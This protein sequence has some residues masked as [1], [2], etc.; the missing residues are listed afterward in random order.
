MTD[1][2]LTREIALRIALAARIFPDMESAQLVRILDSA[3]GLPP[4]AQGI[5]K[6]NSTLLKTAADGDLDD[7]EGD[8]IEQAVAVLKGK[9]VTEEVAPPTVQPY[10]EGEMSGSVRVACSSNTGEELDGHFG[11]CQRFLIYQISQ[12]E[13]RLIDIREPQSPDDDEDKNTL[14]AELIAD[15]HVLL[16]TS[17]G[18]PAAAKVVKAGIHPMKI[19]GGSR[20]RD[21]LKRIQE[22]LGSAPPPWL[23]KA[24]G[25]SEEER[26][27]FERSTEGDLS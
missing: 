25:Q 16:T 9:A 12:E 2:N 14:R 4:S 7:V 11:S 23:A 22:V 18:G 6:L 26:A 15:C 13:I 17:I 21:Q 19:P 20:A 10:H 27:R 1:T 24:M 8:L 5:A 3:I